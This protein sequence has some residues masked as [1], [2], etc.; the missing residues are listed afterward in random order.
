MLDIKKVKED[1]KKE[2]LKEKEEDA[3]GLIKD[4]LVEV[5]DAR[6]IVRNLERELEDLYAD[7]TETF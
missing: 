2:W 5:E 3:K 7:I 1:A 4:K 6:K